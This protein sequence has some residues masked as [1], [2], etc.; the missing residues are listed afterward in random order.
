MKRLKP[1]YSTGSDGKQ[2][3]RFRVSCLH[4][5]TGSLLVT[6]S[7][8]GVV[9]TWIVAT[10][11]TVGHCL[12]PKRYLD[13]PGVQFPLSAKFFLF[14]DMAVGRIM[15]ISLLFLMREF[16]LLMHSLCQLILRCRKCNSNYISILVSTDKT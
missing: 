1:S 13:P 11:E 15:S 10:R 16:Y 3:I 14:I 12:R 7:T 8:N 2:K 4:L 5:Y 9:V 6:I